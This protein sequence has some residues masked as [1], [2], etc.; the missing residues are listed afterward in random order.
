MNK[1]K[2]L[3]MIGVIS[4]LS[5]CNQ[6]EQNSANSTPSEPQVES[7][8]IPVE[9][10]DATENQITR[11]KKSEAICISHGIPIYGNPNSLFVDSDENVVLRT[12]D[13]VVDRA[14]ALM[15]L[16][17]KSEGL[18]QNYLD[19]LNSAYGIFDKMS[20]SEL[21]FAQS[22]NPTQQQMIDANWRYES[23]HVMLWALG[24]ID[25]L[26]YP[27]MMCD[28]SSDVKTIYQLGPDKFREQSVLRSKSEILDQA[29]LILRFDWACV[30]AR[31]KEEPAPASMDASIV[32]ERHYALNWL[33]KYLNQEW[34]D[35][36]T[37]T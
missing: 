15:Y 28:V 21:E 8:T 14:F 20:P 23:L 13:E 37:D 16:G 7:M 33:I 6:E 18:E 11:R 4:S 2:V 12:K 36:T 27:D 35:V 5:G 17:L 26:S 19:D 24:Y 32:Y 22:S 9:N 29:D 31:I 30:S 1:L 3:L 34:D 10:I 25:S